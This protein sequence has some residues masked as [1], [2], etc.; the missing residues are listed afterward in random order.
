[1]IWATSTIAMSV[2]NCL[3]LFGGKGGIDQVEKTLKELQH[4]DLDRNQLKAAVL[5]LEE[6]DAVHRDG[7]FY[8]VND[9]KLRFVISRDLSDVELDKDE[10]QVTGGWSGWTV[11]DPERGLLSFEEIRK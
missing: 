2:Y 6:L 4:P 9:P 1:M 3:I 11:K 7:D 5:R 10:K 8:I